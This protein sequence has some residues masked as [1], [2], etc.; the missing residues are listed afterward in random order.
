M[1]LHSERPGTGEDGGM[2]DNLTMAS[3]FSIQTVDVEELRSQLAQ[4]SIE[5]EEQKALFKK[6]YARNHKDLEEC[7]E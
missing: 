4:R 5:L 2:I 1:E 3:G 6:N 7:Y